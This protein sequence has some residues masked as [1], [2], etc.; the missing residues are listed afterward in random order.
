MFKRIALVALLILTALISA[1][2]DTLHASTRYTANANKYDVRTAQ[3]VARNLIMKYGIGT[4][5]VNDVR[6]RND[7]FALLVNRHGSQT[8]EACYY[9]ALPAPIVRYRDVSMW[10]GK[11]FAGDYYWV[12]LCS[13][14]DVVFYGNKD[15]AVRLADALFS[16][17][18]SSR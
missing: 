5:D 10:E 14:S 1:C 16:L 2:A 15:E 4:L 11:S 13:G 9:S 12:P 18:N 8:T 3:D 17:K 6:F 7:G